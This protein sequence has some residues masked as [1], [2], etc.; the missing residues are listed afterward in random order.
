MG[1]EQPSFAELIEAAQSIPD[2]N[3]G[4]GRDVS[5]PFERALPNSHRVKT[6][7]EGQIAPN[8]DY[9]AHVEFYSIPKQA[10]EYAETLNLILRG[11][12]ILRYEDRTFSKEGDFLVA[13]CYLTF[14]KKSPD[15][16]SGDDDDED[17][18]VT[19]R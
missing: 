4:K 19:I 18:E 11:E 15:K 13:I 10:D 1:K 6:L 17:E 12:G 8:L 5:S 2:P 9:Q 16:K 7:P 3:A 14:K